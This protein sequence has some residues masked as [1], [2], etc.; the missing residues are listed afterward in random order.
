[1]KVESTQSIIPETIRSINAQKQTKNAS[2]F[3]FKPEC[4]HLHDKSPPVRHY[5]PLGEDASRT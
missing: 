4:F 3:P 5:E 2:F 1:M